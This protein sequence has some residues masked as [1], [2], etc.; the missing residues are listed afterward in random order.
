MDVF[1]AEEFDGHEEVLFCND[2]AAGLRAII[3]VHDTSLGPA[4]GGCRMAPYASDE[5]ALADVLRLSRGMTY[6]AAMAG[7]PY[8]GGK[9]V[10][11]GDPRTQK[12]PALLMA[13]A[14]HLDALGGRYVIGADMGTT[15]ADLAI[16]RHLTPYVAS[17]SDGAI[18]DTAPATAW[19]LFHAIRA[20]LMHRTGRD[21]LEGVVVAVQGL[22]KVGLDL[23]R[24]LREA[25]AK[26]IV[27][28]LSDAQVRKAQ[29]A[30]GAAA[31]SPDAILRQR[32][33]VLAPCATGGVINELTLRDLRTTIIA[34]AANNQLDSPRHDRE[35][36][37]LGITYAP[38]YVV[39]AGGV[40]AARYAAEGQNATATYSRVAAI[41]DTLMEVLRRAANAHVPP[42]QMADSMVRERLAAARAGAGRRDPAGRAPMPNIARANAN[43]P[44]A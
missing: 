37:E 12:T 7:L 22:G 35:L 34:G 38:D 39:N 15:N 23:C 16:M 30:F 1:E 24:H 5:D 43:V 2:E 25:G 44:A 8:G 20:A 29:A 13:L 40:I 4:V 6:K 33:H 3:A 19:G 18:A 42:G 31:V 9:T 26:L 27:A 36:A 17:H 11:I 10:I 41:G 14:R 28:D 32:C 21:R